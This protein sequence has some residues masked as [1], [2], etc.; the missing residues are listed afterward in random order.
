VTV[1]PGSGMLPLFTVPCN[2]PPAAAA[3][4]SCEVGGLGA[5]ADA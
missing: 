5:V 3:L 1:T 4:E 2:F